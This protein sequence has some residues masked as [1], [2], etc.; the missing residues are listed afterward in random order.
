M[1]THVARLISE[2]SDHRDCFKLFQSSL[3]CWCNIQHIVWNVRP[4]PFLQET[5]GCLLDLGLGWKRLR[6]F[7]AIRPKFLRQRMSYFKK[8]ALS[9]LI[10]WWAEDLSGLLTLPL[11]LSTALLVRGGISS[12]TL[13]TPR[14]MAAAVLSVKEE[15]Q[16]GAASA[17]LVKKCRMKA[18]S[19]GTLN[20]YLKLLV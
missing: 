14:W 16:D 17:P 9:V 1:R 15:L 10:R 3:K 12:T 20:S 13:S 2:L 5:Q 19:D 7:H 6:D 18:F 8:S 4:I 11:S